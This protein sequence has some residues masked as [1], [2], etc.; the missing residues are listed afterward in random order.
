MPIPTIWSFLGLKT[1][2]TEK[3]AAGSWNLPFCICCIL[4]CCPWLEQDTSTYQRKRPVLSV[5]DVCAVNS[6]CASATSQTDW[7]AW[8]SG[9]WQKTDVQIQA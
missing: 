3:E 2:K 9:R 7:P 4:N 1:G 8:S 5:F 6:S